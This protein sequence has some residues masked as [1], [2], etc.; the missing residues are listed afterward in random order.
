MGFSI[1]VGLHFDIAMGFWLLKVLFNQVIYVNIVNDI[2]STYIF[3]YKS[4]CSKY[5]YLIKY[6]L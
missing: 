6:L 1:Q 2:L 5:I 4:Y 3:P